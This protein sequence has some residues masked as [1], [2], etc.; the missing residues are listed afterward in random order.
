MV[1]M[2]LQRI[3]AVTVALA[4][5]T[6]MA[7][8]LAVMNT[9][10]SV[11]SPTWT[12]ISRFV[13]IL[14]FGTFGLAVAQESQLLRD[15][16]VLHA[17]LLGEDRLDRRR[18]GPRARRLELAGAH[19]DA[20]L[21]VVERVDVEAAQDGHLVCER[22]QRLEGR[23]ELVAAGLDDVVVVVGDPDR[24]ALARHGVGLAGQKRRA[25]SGPRRPSGR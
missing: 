20:R 7:A 5:L 4:L 22:E 13:V 24:V 11:A 23:A 2:R 14:V 18:R 25:T 3:M 16:L 21:R 9:R 12:M 17:D 1:S 8:G 6:A 15:D 10:N 19:A